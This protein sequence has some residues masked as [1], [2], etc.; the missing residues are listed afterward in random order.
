MDCRFGQEGLLIHIAY[1]TPDQPASLVPVPSPTKS[2]LNTAAKDPPDGHNFMEGDLFLLIKDNDVILCPSNLR[3]GAALSYIFWMLQNGASLDTELN[4]YTISAVANLDAVQLI[5]SEGVREL[6]LGA[7]LYTATLAYE[8]RRSSGFDR[9]ES[10]KN[11]AFAFLG[12]ED[13]L[14][15]AER[16]KFANLSARITLSFD[17]RRKG[18][19]VSGEE[20]TKS[21]L[22]LVQFRMDEDLSIKTRKGTAISRDNIRVSRKT[23]LSCS[24]NSVSKL[25]A[26]RVMIDYMKDLRSRGMLSQ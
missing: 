14:S 19:E 24:G 11:L 5:Q 1:Y 20:I 23:Y 26:W 9:V 17:S 22:D 3:E 18:G 6:S 2:V 10:L 15:L 13:S 21:A 8:K 16:K 12:E 25:D 4:R 7:S